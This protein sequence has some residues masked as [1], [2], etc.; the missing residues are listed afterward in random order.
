M[1][2]LYI[3]IY[4]YIFFYL[5]VYC[6]VVISVR[7]MVYVVIGIVKGVELFIGDLSILLC[8]ILSCI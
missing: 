3:Y 7:G 4:I 1:Y 8:G 2:A 6:V 5:L